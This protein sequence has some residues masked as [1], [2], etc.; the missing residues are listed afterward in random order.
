MQFDALTQRAL[1][2]LAPQVDRY[3]GAVA[4]ALQAIR[5]YLAAR[6]YQSDGGAAEAARELGRFAA[7]RVDSSRFAALFAGTRIL[8]SETADRI[9]RCA[10]VLQDLVELGDVLLVHGLTPGRDVRQAADEFLA[11]CGRAFGAVL[12]FQAV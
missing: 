4:Q 10:D 11:Q 6:R 9:E 12:M 8:D 3:Q 7:G 2:A 1:T 5:E